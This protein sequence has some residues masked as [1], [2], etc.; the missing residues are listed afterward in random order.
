[1]TPPEVELRTPTGKPVG[2]V[3]WLIDSSFPDPRFD[4]YAAAGLVVCLPHF[5]QCWVERGNGTSLSRVRIEVLP[6]LRAEYKLPI[7]LAGSGMGGAGALMLA[8]RLR[9]EVPAVFT[10]T[11]T[12]D[13]HEAYGRGTVLDELYRSREACRQDG[14][15]LAVDPFGYPS[16]IRFHCPPNHANHRGNDRLHEKLAALGIE[17]TFSE[18]QPSDDE[19]AATLAAELSKA[20]RRLIT[21][22]HHSPGSVS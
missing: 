2:V 13:F 14:P 11:A 7:A 1:M 10:D 9:G 5:D 17:H 18:T 20:G 16:S 19:L 12:I 15:I 8:F 6:R 4:A 3:V 22:P 21:L